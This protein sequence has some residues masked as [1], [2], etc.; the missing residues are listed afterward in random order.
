MLERGE[1]LVDPK[2]VADALIRELSGQRMATE[3]A[4]L[5]LGDG[6]AVGLAHT[7]RSRVA[8]TPSGTTA[9]AA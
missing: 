3:Y 1:Y 8:A 5:T 2:A 6:R 9:L 7:K 4:E